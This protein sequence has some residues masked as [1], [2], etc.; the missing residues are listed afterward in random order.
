[1]DVGLCLDCIYKMIPKNGFKVFILI[2][3][4]EG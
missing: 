1:M 4:K 2:H 3:K